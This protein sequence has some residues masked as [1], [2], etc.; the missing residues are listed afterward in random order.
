MA[1]DN[2]QT[3]T[4]PATPKL[5]QELEALHTRVQRM[6]Q[7]L[8]GAESIL[9]T[10][11]YDSHLD[12]SPA[13]SERADAHHRAYDMIE[14]VGNQLEVWRAEEKDLDFPSDDIWELMD[15][16]E[17]GKLIRYGE[18]IPELVQ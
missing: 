10:I 9:S 7:L 2:V 15:K 5:A 4:G 17:H 14:F 11:R 1:N 3:E 13:A 8:R 18:C 12:Y 6:E 16:A